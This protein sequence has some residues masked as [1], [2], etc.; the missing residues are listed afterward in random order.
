MPDQPKP[1]RGYEG[2]DRMD[3]PPNPLGS[4]HSD[5]AE[6]RRLRAENG[7]LREVL[8]LVAAG[9]RSDGSWNRDREACRALAEEALNE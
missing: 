6:I 7:R 9:R 1:A 3:R 2:F 8:A 5:R 4:L